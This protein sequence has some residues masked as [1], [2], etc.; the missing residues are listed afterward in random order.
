MKNQIPI[1]TLHQARRDFLKSGVALAATGCATV[2]PQTQNRF[3]DSMLDLAQTYQ[4]RIGVMAI[5]T[6]TGRTL[7]FADQRRFAMALNFQA[8]S[9]CFCIVTCRPGSTSPFPETRTF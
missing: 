8:A 2:R 6:E 9:G 4:T 1:K 3:A 7:G 5:D